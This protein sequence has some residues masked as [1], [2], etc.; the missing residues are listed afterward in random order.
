MVPTGGSVAADFPYGMHPVPRLAVVDLHHR[1]VGAT[2]HE[3]VPALVVECVVDSELQTPRHRAPKPRRGLREVGGVARL[4]CARHSEYGVGAA[5]VDAPAVRDAALPRISLL[6][7][8]E[9]RENARRKVRTFGVK[10]VVEGHRLAAPHFAQE[11][12][13]VGRIEQLPLLRPSLAHP[14]MVAFEATH[15]VE[16]PAK[17]LHVFRTLKLLLYNPLCVSASLR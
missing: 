7:H 2:G 16:M 14:L 11:V 17:A 12:E 1:V 9:W 8:P 10:P 15:A 6:P 5:G 3:A 4:V 13:V